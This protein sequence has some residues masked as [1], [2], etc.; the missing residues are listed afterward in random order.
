MGRDVKGWFLCVSPF[1]V[2]CQERKRCGWRPLVPT[3][4][5]LPIE[6]FVLEE[7]EPRAGPCRIELEGVELVSKLVDL[8]VLAL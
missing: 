1:C 7:L 6:A 4:M 5:V 8:G 3:R 2:W